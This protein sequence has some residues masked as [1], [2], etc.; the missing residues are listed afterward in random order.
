MGD[1]AGRGKPEAGAPL[2]A[3][4]RLFPI[5]RPSLCRL[6]RSLTRVWCSSPERRRDRRV[7][8][9]LDRPIAQ[10]ALT[11]SEELRQPPLPEP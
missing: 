5:E 7:V 4:P 11:A 2:D 3:G 6:S 1:G 8:D 10:K 9:L